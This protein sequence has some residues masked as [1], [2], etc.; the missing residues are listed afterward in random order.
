TSFLLES[1]DRPLFA[2]GVT[3]R[4]DPW[5]KRGLR[6]RGFDAEGLATAPRDIIADGRLTGWL[7]DSASA[8]QLGLGPT[9]HA[10]RGTAG[11]PGVSPSNLWL[12]AGVQSVEDLMS[13]IK[14]GVYLTELIG[15]GV[16][17]LTGDYSRGAGGFRIRNG[18]LAEPLSEVTVAGHLIDMFAR[19]VPA[20][21]L[22]FRHA[23]NAPT[24]RI[25]GMTVAGQG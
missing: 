13:D 16:N 20:S 3:I 15:M 8:R 18:T 10:S 7:L 14:D 11:P 5:R 12:E 1:L 17:I 25:D 4:D 22:E 19:L 2:P 24:V 9:G 6:S 23:V 21:D